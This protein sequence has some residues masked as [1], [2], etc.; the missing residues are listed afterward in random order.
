MTRSMIANLINTNR[1]ILSNAGTLVGTQA[2]TSG[3]GFI[4]WWVAARL[5]AVDAVG[6]ASAAISAMMLLGNLG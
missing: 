4:Y 3:L 2:V 6:F 1:V 5:F